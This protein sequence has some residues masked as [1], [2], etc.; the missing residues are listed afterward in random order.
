VRSRVPV[1]ETVGKRSR[2]SAR[3]PALHRTA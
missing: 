2:R 1:E 3:R